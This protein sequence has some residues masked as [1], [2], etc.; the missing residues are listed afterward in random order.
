MMLIVEKQKRIAIKI[1][2]SDGC[3]A[4]GM[5]RKYKCCLQWQKILIVLEKRVKFDVEILGIERDLT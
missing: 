1:T 3:I 4:K 5:K 2:K